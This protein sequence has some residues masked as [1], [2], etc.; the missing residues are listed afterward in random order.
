MW[1]VFQIWTNFNLFYLFGVPQRWK[2]LLSKDLACL[3]KMRKDTE[4]H[5]S[6]TK[7]AHVGNNYQQVI[8]GFIDVTIT[9]WVCMIFWC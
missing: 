5:N 3:Q 9:F 4:I 1:Y 2:G 8:L 7:N 6:P